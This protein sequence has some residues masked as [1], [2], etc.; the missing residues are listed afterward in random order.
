M[1]ELH[2][3]NKDRINE[4]RRE[5]AALHKKQEIETIQILKLAG[6]YKEPKRNRTAPEN[7]PGKPTRKKPAKKRKK[8]DDDSDTDSDS[9]TDTN[10]IDSSKSKPDTGTN[11]IDSSKSK[12]ERQ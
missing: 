3:I 10:N 1:G 12:S 4:K 7:V 2:A 9:D 6:V 11:N 8:K 5:R